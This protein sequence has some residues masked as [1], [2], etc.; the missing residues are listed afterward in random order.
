MNNQN[1]IEKIKNNLNIVDV[2]REYLPN[3]KRSGS[4]HFGLCPFHSEKTGSFSVSEEMQI[5]KCFGCGKSGDVI[6]FIQEMESLTFPEALKIAAKRAGVQLTDYKYKKN[7]EKQRT[8]EKIFEINRLVAEYYSYILTSHKLGKRG[9][10]YAQK[11]NLGE[12]VIKKFLIGYAPESYNNL[13]NFLVSKKYNIEDLVS[14]SLIVKKNSRIYDKFRDRLIFPIFDRTGNV[15]GFSGRV[16]D[17]NNIPKYLNSSETPAYKK[18]DV[19]YG[20]HQARS[21]IRQKKYVIL[22]EGNV[23]VPTAHQHDIQNIVAPMGTALT[24]TQLKVLKRY[25]DTIF[26]C[27]DSDTAGEKALIR[28]YDLAESIGFTSKVI[29]LGNHNDLDE[30]LNKE[31]ENAKDTIKSALPFVE[32]I[33]AKKSKNIKENS[34]E[35]Y[36]NFVNELIPYIKRIKDTIEKGSYI[37]KLSQITGLNEK[38][39]WDKLKTQKSSPVTQQQRIESIQQPQKVKLPNQELYLIAYV[40]HYPFLRKKYKKYISKILSEDALNIL[41]LVLSKKDIQAELTKMDLEQKEKVQNII[42]YPFQQKEDREDIEYSFYNL[43]KHLEKKFIKQQIS[44][45]KRTI[46]LKE[47]RN[48]SIQK[49]LKKINQLR[50][51]LTTNTPSPT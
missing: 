32:Y 3:L 43:L 38:L 26:F 40:K 29:D 10:E 49:D 5:F 16:I 33:I 17:N 6:T 27:F 9:K 36:S 50:K 8:I 18:S 4:G 20:L 39:I 47:S 48:E 22:V 35:E 34:P 30:L 28:S 1:V 31:P 15:I 42:L 19:L 12:D 25:T 23:D 11:R 41:N 2:I 51:T 45:L 14:W 24:L 44:L 7:P 46:S 21:S 13:K 37:Q